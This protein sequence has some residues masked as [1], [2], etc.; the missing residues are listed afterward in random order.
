MRKPSEEKILLSKPKETT[1]FIGN[2]SVCRTPPKQEL[3]T[4]LA[5]EH[6]LIFPHLGLHSRAEHERCHTWMLALW[7]GIPE[8]SEIRTEIHKHTFQSPLLYSEHRRGQQTALPTGKAEHLFAARLLGLWG[9]SGGEKALSHT[10]I[11]CNF[12][13]AINCRA[14][15]KQKHEL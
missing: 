14:G 2:A 9:S 13:K 6:K 5:E 11:S 10:V 8:D 1:E 7:L 3:F 15:R 4:A 12:R